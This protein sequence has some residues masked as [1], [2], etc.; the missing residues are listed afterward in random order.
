[1]KW[2]AC[3]PDNFSCSITHS[4]PDGIRQNGLCRKLSHKPLFRM[5][6]T[7]DLHVIIRFDESMPERRY[8][9]A[10]V[11]LVISQSIFNDE[12]G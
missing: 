8:V 5:A 10:P 4:M 9:L 3:K 11:P 1:M 6:I 2:N 7:K 12:A